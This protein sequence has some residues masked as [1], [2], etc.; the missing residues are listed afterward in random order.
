MFFFFNL[1]M[2]STLGSILFETEHTLVSQCFANK[3][4]PP[5]LLQEALLIGTASY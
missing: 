1:E 3:I 5:V 4:M 2:K